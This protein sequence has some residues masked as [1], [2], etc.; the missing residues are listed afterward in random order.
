MEILNTKDASNR[1]VKYLLYGESK[2]GKT[3]LVTTLPPEHTLLVNIE[4]NLTSVYGADVN[5]VNA[6]TFDKFL[7]VV[8]YLESGEHQFKW[9]FIDSL[10]EL[11]SILLREELGK[12]KDGR[13]AYGELGQKL[14]EVIRR[15]R[16]LPLNIVAVGQQG[17]IKDEVTG[18]LLFGASMAGQKL[19]QSLPYMFDAVIAVRRINF[20][21]G[22][23]TVLQ[24]QPD[25][26]YHVG[27][28]T[29]YNNQQPLAGYEAANLLS[30]HNKII[31][32]EN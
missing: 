16:A 28:R 6:F 29:N 18:G 19:E 27:V 10:T 1:F 12:T 4:N 23:Q 13:Q 9:V 7:E 30:L 8:S 21:T 20:E 31:N 2:S 14:P 24:C 15:L 11:G 22:I 3:R 25:T 26:Q 5:T 17:Q 32:T